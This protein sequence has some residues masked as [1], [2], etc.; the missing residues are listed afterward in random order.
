MADPNERIRVFVTAM[1]VDRET[2]EVLP[3]SQ[4]WDLSLDEFERI[5]RILGDPDRIRI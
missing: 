1:V 3:G 4:L 2:E 5:K